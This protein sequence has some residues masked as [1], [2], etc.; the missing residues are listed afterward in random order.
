M[1]PFEAKLYIEDNLAT[2]EF[3]IM[4]KGK[5]DVESLINWNFAVIKVGFKGKP[6]LCVLSVYNQDDM[7]AVG[8][9][10]SPNYVRITFQNTPMAREISLKFL[11]LYM[12]GKWCLI[13]NHIYP[14]G[15]SPFDKKFLY[16]NKISIDDM[17]EYSSEVE[18]LDKKG[19]KTGYKTARIP[20][21]KEVHKG[22]HT[23]TYVKH[24]A[25]LNFMSL[26]TRKFGDVKS[27]EFESKPAWEVPEK[28][29]KDEIA[30][31]KNIRQSIEQNKIGKLDK[32]S[33]SRTMLHGLFDDE[34]KDTDDPNAE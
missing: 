16:E 28:M 32:F 19:R 4:M 33:I 1:P 17:D 6:R 10:L 31:L 30:S 18:L 26:R 8:E 34:G 20:T 12:E 3:D 14:E 22:N 21:L 15:V 27:T 2:I 5:Y 7:K 24:S 11:D 9:I 29:G 23:Y 13:F 25:S